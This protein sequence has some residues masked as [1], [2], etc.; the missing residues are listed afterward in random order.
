LK[1]G[2][3]ERQ[4]IPN[5]VQWGLAQ[6]NYGRR[7]FTSNSD[8]LRGDLF[9]SHYVGNEP[10]IKL[11]GLNVRVASDQAT[12]PGRVNPG[13]NRGYEK[14]TLREDGTLAA[15]TAACGTVIYRG[16]L[17]PR[18]FQGNAFV[19]EP[20]GNLIRRNILTEHQGMVTAHNAY[21]KSEF[22]TST[23]ERFRPVNLYTGP[24]GAL[25]IL[26]IYHG[27]VQHRVYLTTYLRRQAEERGL[28]KPIQQ[29]RIYRVVPDG[30]AGVPVAAPNLEKA[31]AGLLVSSLAHPN[32]WVRDTA[33]RLLVHG[34]KKEA[35]ELLRK[36]ALAHSNPLARLHALWTLEG[37]DQVDDGTLT[38]AL[39]DEHPEIRRAALRLSEPFL[40]RTTEG[41]EEKR[42]RSRVLALS[43]DAAREV[44]MQLSLSL[45]AAAEQPAIR[46][47]LA[48]LSREADASSVARMASF[49]L[50]RRDPHLKKDEPEKPAGRPLSEEEQKQF[51]LGKEIYF[52]TCIACHQPHGLGQEGLAPPLVG[53]K[54]VG[55]SSDRLARIILHGLRGPI[56]VKGESYEMDMPALGVLDDEQIAAA[57]TYVRREWGHAY[58]PVKPEDVAKAREATA[59]REDAWTVDELMKIP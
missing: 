24:D 11:D 27:I 6:D 58:D 25:Y 28:D 36:M 20:A 30:G 57:L 35:V 51:V 10:G 16:H 9:P 13:V 44:R 22:L 47:T 33:Q 41:P 37:L 59:G 55:Y 38:S 56:E 49:S 5:R 40:S 45:G 14:G 4:P 31:D 54:W 18:E 12:W 29:G 48:A 52:I 1:G 46:E 7:F 19:C 53:S 23:D 26:D 17:F 15:F 43:A 42:V 32:G 3:W 2:S 8:Q 34:G 21:D 39:E 50:S